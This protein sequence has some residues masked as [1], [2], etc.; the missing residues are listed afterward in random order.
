VGR[1]KR[2][3]GGTGHVKTQFNLLKPRNYTKG[4]GSRGK[5]ETSERTMETVGGYFVASKKKTGEKQPVTRTEKSRKQARS[6][7]CCESAS[8]KKDWKTRAI[9]S[10]SSDTKASGKMK[11]FSGPASGRKKR[12]P[13]QAG[14]PQGGGGWDRKSRL[15]K[16]I[17]N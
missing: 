5:L 6:A 14:G 1:K 7:R 17:P 2:N 16:L 3:A 15:K 12:E 4:Q 13:E 9:K 11:K 10:Q 8:K